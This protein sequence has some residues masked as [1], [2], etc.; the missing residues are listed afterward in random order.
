MTIK[1][2]IKVIDPDYHGEEVAEILNRYDD[3]SEGVREAHR[4]VIAALR[5]HL[6][7]RI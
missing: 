5:T 7:G 6:G 3:L 1:E 4:I 2:A